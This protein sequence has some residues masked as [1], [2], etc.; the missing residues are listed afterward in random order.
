MKSSSGMVTGLSLLIAALGT[1]MAVSQE[2][3]GDGW[4]TLFNGTDLDQ[5]ILLGD[6]NWTIVDDVV[7]ADSGSGFLVSAQTYGDFHL[8]LEFWTDT[9]ANSGVF[10]RCSDSNDIGSGNAYEI[11]IFDKRPDQTY[12][13]GGIVNF[14]APTSIIDAA[15]QWNTY[16]ITAQGSRL[17]VEL[18][19]TVTA[20]IEDT[21]YSAGPI[22]LQYGAGIVKFRRVRIRRL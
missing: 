10:I 11:N 13:T 16:E 14:S 17:L 4:A 2:N 9:D 22:A 3:S 5:W 12:R 15:N 18:N 19:G 1:S 6:A 7:Q 8:T 20:D 21:T